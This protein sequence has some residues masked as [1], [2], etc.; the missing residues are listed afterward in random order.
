[1]TYKLFNAWGLISLDDGIVTVILTATPDNGNP[2]TNTLREELPTPTGLKGSALV[3]VNLD[4]REIGVRE[5]TETAVLPHPAALRA[6][7]KAMRLMKRE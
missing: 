7:S 2:V 6:L 4:T 5:L 1:M 3:A